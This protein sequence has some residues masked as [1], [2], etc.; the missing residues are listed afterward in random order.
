MWKDYWYVLI[1]VHCAT[2]VVWFGGFY[3][4][5]KAGIDVPGILAYLGTSEAYLEKVG[6][7]SMGYYALAYA[8]YKIATPAR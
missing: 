4:M 3:F 5:C 8:C 1:P 2:S 6:N 7:S